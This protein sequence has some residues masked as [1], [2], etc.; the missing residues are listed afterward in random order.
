ML[1]KRTLY[2]APAKNRENSNW[3]LSSCLETASSSRAHNL[4]PCLGEGGRDAAITPFSWLQPPL[5]SPSCFLRSTVS[6]PPSLLLSLLLSLPS[7]LPSF[8]PA[9]LSACLPTVIYSW[10]H[11]IWVC[12]QCQMLIFLTSK[13]SHTTARQVMFKSFTFQVY[14]MSYKLVSNTPNILLC[15]TVK[16]PFIDLHVSISGVWL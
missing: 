2:V 15:V 8:L 16:W 3:V 13:G 1:L 5:S 6:L 12:F 14:S 7:L 9:C 4:S 11:L 10:G